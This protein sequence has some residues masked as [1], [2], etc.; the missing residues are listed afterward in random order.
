MSCVRV[1]ASQTPGGGQ[2][3]NYLVCLLSC[4]ANVG[5]GSLLG[6]TQGP[7]DLESLALAIA[8]MAPQTQAGSGPQINGVAL[9]ER[10]QAERGISCD[11]LRR[12]RTKSRVDAG[13]R[14]VDW[15]LRKAERRGRPLSPT[16]RK[17]IAKKAA[18]ARW[19]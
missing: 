9:D 15:G 5:I 17:A 19:G 10:A 13:E 7:T 11:L 16:E 3:Q 14:W 12:V 8:R 18:K 1:V 4:S 6:S 2:P